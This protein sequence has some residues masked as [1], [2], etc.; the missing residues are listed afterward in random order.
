MIFL[1]PNFTVPM[2]FLQP[3]TNFSGLA[4]GFLVQHLS[5]PRVS[6]CVVYTRHHFKVLIASMVVDPILCRRYEI[7]CKTIRDEHVFA[8]GVIGI[9]RG[10]KDP[11]DVIALQRLNLN[12]ISL[13]NTPPL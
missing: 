9:I 6:V 12:F 1:Q 11:A 5:F 10:A 4:T 3:N 8:I 13:Q 7:L 2:I